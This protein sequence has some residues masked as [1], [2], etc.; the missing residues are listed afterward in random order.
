L[1]EKLLISNPDLSS[2]DLAQEVIK[3]LKAWAVRL[4]ESKPAL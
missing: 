2:Q 4:R 3:R 1:L